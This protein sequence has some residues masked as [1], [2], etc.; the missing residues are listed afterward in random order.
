MSRHQTPRSSFG[1]SA[2][3]ATP[4]SGSSA[5][6]I[7]RRRFIKAILRSFAALGQFQTSSSTAMQNM[8]AVNV[9]NG[10]HR[11]GRMQNRRKAII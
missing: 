2:A 8:K 7:R 1:I 5:V 6:A 10:L 9:R 4:V 11:Q 3:P